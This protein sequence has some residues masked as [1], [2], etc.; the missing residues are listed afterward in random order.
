M[1]PDDLGIVA[2]NKN[3]L[4]IISQDANGFCFAYAAGLRP[5]VDIIAGMEIA[6]VFL[7]PGS[8]HFNTLI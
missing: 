4:V 5:K 8:F 3:Y 1:L 6:A 7:C 2:G